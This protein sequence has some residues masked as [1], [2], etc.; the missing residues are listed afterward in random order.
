[1]Y[2]TLI[3]AAL[4]AAVAIAAPAVH[5]A[6]ANAVR[7]ADHMTVSLHQVDFQNPD[8]VRVAYARL[9]AAAHSVCDSESGNIMIQAEDRACEQ[10]A[11]RDAL[12]DLQQ[13]ALYRVADADRANHKTPQQFAFN[14]RR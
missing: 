11:I 6:D 9:T 3:A 8:Q 2:K 10:Q 4:T 7:T 14:D 13:P 12:A 1:M 5:A